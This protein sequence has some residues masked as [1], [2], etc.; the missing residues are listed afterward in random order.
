MLDAYSMCVCVRV[1]MLC[2]MRAL[3]CSCMYVRVCLFACSS[4]TGSSLGSQRRRRDAAAPGN[5]R[6]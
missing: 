2:D 1:G 6:A 5:R 4:D 3:E